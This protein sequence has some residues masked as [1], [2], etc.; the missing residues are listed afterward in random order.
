MVKK[1][2]LLPEA[3]PGNTDICELPAELALGKRDRAEVLLP[4]YFR[5]LSE[6][7]RNVRKCQL[8]MAHNKFRIQCLGAGR[9]VRIDFFHVRHEVL[10]D[11]I[12]CNDSPGAV[13]SHGQP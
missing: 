1:A 7:T 10:A 13:A 11:T 6:R 12:L 5:S 9:S 2:E 3:F 8:Y 4:A